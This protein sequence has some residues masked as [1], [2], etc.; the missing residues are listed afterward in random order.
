MKDTPIDSEVVA[1]LI[2]E[3]EIQHVGRATI[4]ELVALINRI[5]A[6]TGDR[7]QIVETRPLSKDKRFRLLKI[8]GKGK[9]S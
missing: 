7:V 6:E 3:S 4:R 2:K 1:R 8:V 5:E 9:V